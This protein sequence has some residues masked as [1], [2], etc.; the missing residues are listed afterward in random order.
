MIRVKGHKKEGVRTY[1][2]EA[3][4][5]FPCGEWSKQHPDGGEREFESP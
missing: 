4:V 2:G 5:T 3:R 1:S